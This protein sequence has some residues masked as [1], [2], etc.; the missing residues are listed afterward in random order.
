MPDADALPAWLTLLLLP[1]RSGDIV[2]YFSCLPWLGVTAWGLVLGRVLAV[3]RTRGLRQSGIVGLGLMA[4]ACSVAYAGGFGNVAVVETATG[5]DWTGFVKYGPS[6]A[7]VGWNVGIALAALPIGAWVLARI[8]SPQ[9][10]LLTYGRSA[11]FFYVCHL[12]FFGAVA[13]MAGSP[14]LSLEGALA[15]WAVGLVC[16]WPACTLYGRFKLTTSPDSVWRLL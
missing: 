10:P 3:D 2:V 8:R 11:L 6:L 14:G 9:G 12:A 5:R 15:V 1:G 4:A 16:L 7:F 13:W